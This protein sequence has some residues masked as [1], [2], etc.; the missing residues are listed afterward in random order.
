MSTI[1]KLNTSLE[2]LRNEVL[3]TFNKSDCELRDVEALSESLMVLKVMQGYSEVIEELQ[4]KLRSV[5]FMVKHMYER[6]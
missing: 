2:E 5:E 6:S 1:G 3:E 4:E